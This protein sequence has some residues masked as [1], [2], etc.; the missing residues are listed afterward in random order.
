LRKE[1]SKIE[2]RTT[3]LLAEEAR[4]HAALAD[5]AADH[6]SVLALDAELRAVLAERDELEDR[7]LEVAAELE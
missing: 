7:W 1:M 5:A 6:T 2:R 3:K 4:L